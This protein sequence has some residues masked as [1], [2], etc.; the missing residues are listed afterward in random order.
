MYERPPALFA[1]QLPVYTVRTVHCLA[2]ALSAVLFIQN[3][4]PSLPMCSGRTR[5]ERDETGY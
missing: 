5:P 2:P 1:E 4:S 3:R